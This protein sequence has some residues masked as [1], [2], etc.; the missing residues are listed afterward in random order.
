MP[1]RLDCKKSA[2]QKAAT[3]AR[4]RRRDSRAGGPPKLRPLTASRVRSAKRGHTLESVCPAS[5]SSR[6]RLKSACTQLPRSLWYGRVTGAGWLFEL[7]SHSQ[8]S[9]HGCCHLSPHWLT[10]AA[11]RY[12]L[13]GASDALCQGPLVGPLVRPVLV[14]PPLRIPRL[15]V[16][17]C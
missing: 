3:K 2:E 6:F 7:H 17:A 15:E 16:L 13:P 5:S 14:G 8:A 4:A 9:G 10:S 12:Y 1:L 11:S